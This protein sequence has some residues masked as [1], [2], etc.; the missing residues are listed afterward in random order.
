MT[1]DFDKNIDEKGLSEKYRLKEG[2]FETS[3]ERYPKKCGLCGGDVKFA[4]NK[5]VYGNNDWKGYVYL[6][7]KCGAYVGT[8]RPNSR[9][10]IGVLSNKVMR[11]L[12]M[13][14][15]KLFDNMDF[16]GRTLDRRYSWFQR[17]LN[18]PRHQCRFGYFELDTLVNV[19]EFLIECYE[20]NGV[21]VP[22]LIE[23]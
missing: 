9:V 22:K 7:T 3:Y 6:C 21:K 10:A 19:R 14:C 18:I 8:Y 11:N 2:E 12:R 15:H 20:A 1:E 4:N 23:D 16:D 17:T 13:D 5:A